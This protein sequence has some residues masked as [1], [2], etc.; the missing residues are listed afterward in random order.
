MRNQAFH[1]AERFRQSKTL[2]LVYESFYALY[3]AP[4][5]EAHHCSESIL[6]RGSDDVARMPGQSRVINPLHRRVTI[7][8]VDHSRCVLAVDAYARMQRP[9]PAQRE[10]TV[11]RR[12]RDS[13]TV[14][15]PRQLFGESCFRGDHCASDHVAVAVE[16]FRRRMNHQIR[17]ELDRPLESWREEGVVDTDDGSR[18]TSRADDRRQV[19]DA[20]QRIAWR[21]YP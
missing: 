8:R 11:K 20:Q 10:K 2:Q 14:C 13:K 21:L 16:V 18:L 15:P 9:N 4:N 12:A 6:L 19:R 5:L 17:P 7:Q 1:T 3:A